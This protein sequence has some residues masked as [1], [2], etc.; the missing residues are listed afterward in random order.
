MTLPGPGPTGVDQ[1]E[2]F[3][4]LRL[5]AARNQSSSPLSS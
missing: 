1:I 5:P 3:G 2:F 4:V